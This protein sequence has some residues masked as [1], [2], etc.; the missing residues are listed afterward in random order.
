MRKAVAVSISLAF[1][2]LPARSGAIPKGTQVQTYR[3]GL[4]FPVDM[5]WVPGTRKIFVTEKNT[6]K[7]RVVVGKK[8]LDTPCVTLP[9][10]SEGEQGALGIAIHPRFKSNHKLYVMY[11]NSSPQVMKVMRFTV[12]RNRC[13]NPKKILSG[14]PA[15]AG[16]HNG[17]Q[18]EFGG[19]KLFV[20]TGENHDPSLA[21]D[22]NNRSGKILRLNSDGSVPGDNPYSSPGDPNPVWSYGHRNPFGL[23]YNARTGKLYESE[24]G[25]SC[26]DELNL[27]VRGGNYGWGSSQKCPNTDNSGP[28]P[29][30]PLKSWT[31]TIVPTDLWWYFGK[32]KSLS[33][34]LFMGDYDGHLHRF[35]M[36]DSG[37]AVVDDRIIYRG[38]GIVDV[39]KGPGGW[40]YFI[41]GGSIK[42]IV[43]R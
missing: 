23:A 16:Y 13:R 22:R 37:T 33:G 24:N 32:L 10:A 26:N 9:V 5:A 27:I 35:V 14:V 3:A 25:P 8:L 20:G 15:G 21:Q 42:R 7:I 12:R 18:I 38:G 4:D 41:E 30:S 28:D 40:L 34:D 43:P 11:T 36:N 31:P 2:L 1:A 17:G 6:G 29:I 39:A 19:S